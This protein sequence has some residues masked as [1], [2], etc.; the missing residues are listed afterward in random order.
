[1][2]SYLFIIDLFLS[3]LLSSLTSSF[4]FHMIITI[5]GTV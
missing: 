4:I 3:I 2:Q 5:I 1:L